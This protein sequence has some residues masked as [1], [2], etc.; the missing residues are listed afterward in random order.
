MA[1]K[2]F[3]CVDLGTMGTK[4]AIV[5]V[6]GNIIARTVE[7]SKLYYPQPGRVEQ[8]PE[9]MYRSTIDT[10][11]YLLEET[12]ISSADIA[13][14]GISGQMAG[15]MGIDRNWNAVTHYDSWL[16]NRCQQ[17]V[18]VM[19][20]KGEEKYIE[21]NGMPVT[22]A[23]AAKMLWWK[24]E[25]PDTYQKIYKF[26]QPA[27]YVAGR[28]AD[29]DGEEAFVDYTYLHFSGLYDAEEMTWSEEMA[30][31]LGLSLEKMPAI[32]RP[33]DIIGYLSPAAADK[34]G[35]QADI[36]IIAGAGDTAVSFLGTGLTETGILVDIAGTASV[37]SCCVNKFR[38]DVK[39]RTLI[40]PR[41]I[42]TEYWYPLSYIGGGGLCLR[43]FR[44]T[45]AGE[46][47][48]KA[49]ENDTD[50]Y[51]LLDK[52]AAGVEPGSDGLIFIPH[53]AGR[54]YPVDSKVKG[55]WT[56]FSWSHEK[57]HFYRSILESIAYEYRYYLKII[58]N[59]FP[60]TPF[61][62]VR[63]IGGGSKS[64]LWNQI[65]ADVLGI[66]YTR[67]NEEDV[68]LIGMAMTAAKGV[69]LVD[70]ITA[71][72]N[73]IVRTTNRFQPRDE[74]HRLYS[75]YADL[76]EKMLDDLGSSYLELENIKGGI[77]N[78]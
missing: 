21:T 18:E 24:N 76:Y 53:L 3:I 34:C 33:W 28:L 74:Y 16:D 6:D 73:S 13:A 62:E 61:S 17:Y 29:L 25:R 66:P 77:D 7:E 55:N 58:K 69:G 67:I 49:R 2:F 38:P 56:G 72:I 37:F 44:D 48:R 46:E 50:P 19:K 20:E 14:I 27:S 23:H 22:I 71:R 54:T 1:K 60:E 47:K 32:V 12:D 4:T 40:F 65:K 63:V 52:M 10:I 51:Y 8:K 30:D 42:Q 11:S 70:D 31:L 68:G 9:R 75:Q 36:P 59:L 26:M 57:G 41:S 43:W 15:I 39:N 45:F 64:D 35:L 5:S 78:G